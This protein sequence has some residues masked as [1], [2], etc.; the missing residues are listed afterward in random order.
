MARSLF[1]EDRLSF[2]MHL[3]HGMYPD[4]FQ[5]NEW[6]AFIGL[7]VNDTTDG[8]DY[9]GLHL[10]GWLGM[11]SHKKVTDNNFWSL[12]NFIKNFES[13]ITLKMIHEF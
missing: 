2:A 11:I 6:E 5:E 9:E 4:M 3:A 1:K 10:P 7:L 13:K 8:N 12:A